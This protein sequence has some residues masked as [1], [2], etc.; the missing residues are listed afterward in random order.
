MTLKQ[1]RKLKT[2]DFD[3]GAVRDEIEKIIEQHDALVMSLE[4]LL[5]SPCCN[6][7]DQEDETA[8]AIGEC[9]EALGKVYGA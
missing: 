5:D 7:D 8:A 4:R 2:R 1:F 3:N 9:H 6:E